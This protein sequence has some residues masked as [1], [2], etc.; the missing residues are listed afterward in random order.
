VA[1]NAIG[2]PSRYKALPAQRECS[3][4]KSAPANVSSIPPHR[5]NGDVVVLS[6]DA[7]GLGDLTGGFAADLARALEAEALRWRVPLRSGRPGFMR[8]TVDLP[9][10]LFRK[11]KAIAAL[12][13]S[14]L[15]SL[16][17]QAVEKEVNGG[18]AK[19]GKKVRLPLVRM[20]IGRKLHPERIDFDDLLA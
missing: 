2:R 16:I 12:R 11:T 18:S 5:D 3:Q 7:R 17:V 4:G 8:T 13:G 15:K 10:D 14:S 19:D 6:P 9:D 1:S 20:P